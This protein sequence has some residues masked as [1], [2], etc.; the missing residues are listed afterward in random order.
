MVFGIKDLNFSH[1]E[2]LEYVANW[3]LGKSCFEVSLSAMEEL[4][5]NLEILTGGHAGLCA[6]AIRALNQVF[7][8]KCASDLPSADEWIRTLRTGSLYLPDDNELFQALTLTR[9]VKVLG[10]L[11][12]E[13]LN[14]LERIA[15]GANP[16]ADPSIVDQCIRK[17]IL[18]ESERQIDFSS[19][20]M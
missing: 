1:A 11:N 10:S 3:F 13:D 14:R 8:S 17:G 19:S 4:S 5:A 2:V 9:A 12:V 16:R 20:V 6:T 18:V 15:S 7:R